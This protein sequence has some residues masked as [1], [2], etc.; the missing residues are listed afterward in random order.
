LCYLGLGQVDTAVE[1]LDRAV[2]LAAAAG[3][4][5]DEAYWLRSKGN[6]FVLK[7]HYDEGLENHRAALAIYERLEG[8]TERVEALHDMGRVHFLLGDVG[9]AESRYR[10]S[11]DLAREL[12]LTRGIT[13]NLLALGDLQFMRSEYDAA[14]ALYMQGAQRAK[15]SGEMAHWSQSLLRLAAAYI[16]QQNPV[17]SRAAALQALDI[18]RETGALGLETQAIYAIAELDRRQE[19]L[20]EALRGYEQVIAALA[21]A[22]DSDL[23]WRAH[24]GKGLALAEDGRLDQAIRA[25]QSAIEVIEGVRDRLQQERFRAGYL[26]NKFQVYVDLVRLQLEAGRS[27]DAFSTAERLRTRS[28][29]DLVQGD[30]PPDPSEEDQL[31]EFALKERIRALREALAGEQG[32]TRPEQRQAAISVYSQELL[33]AEQEYQAFLDEHRLSGAA[34]RSDVIPTYSEVRAG[35]ADDEALVEYVVGQNSVM[36]FV[37]TRDELAAGKALLRREDLEN[38]V[39]LVR[40]LIRRRDNNRWR[41]PAASLARYLLEPVLEN[42]LLEGIRHL[43]LVP[44]GSL[45]YLP[46]GLLPSNQDDSRRMIQD[47]TLAYLPTAAVLL[48]PQIDA[49]GSPSMLAMAPCMHYSLRIPWYYLVNPQPRVRSRRKRC[50][51]VCCTWPPMVIST[52]SIR[53]YPVWNWSQTLP[54][55]ASSNCM[56]FSACN[57]QPTW[58]P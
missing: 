3:M 1:H 17:E 39:E 51:T 25:L 6:A 34:G 55:T 45:N 16:K 29:L 41:K 48:R 9:S 14:T 21:M 33:A 15:E 7:G 32:L 30:R 28:Y 36:W 57:S 12:G 38:K 56:R 23:E 22:P 8:R 2:E 44:H 54:M 52:S 26:Q 27:G 4:Q 50:T 24:H 13:L 35:L 46:F 20:A 47:F 31:L 19:G 49:T 42:N 37:L 18:A 40:N 5:Q 10:Q 53:C 11:M 43:Y 58:S